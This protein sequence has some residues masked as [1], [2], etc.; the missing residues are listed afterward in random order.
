MEKNNLLHCFLSLML[1]CHKTL[2]GLLLHISLG[3]LRPN[4]EGAD[5]CICS[6]NNGHNIDKIELADSIFWTYNTTRFTRTYQKSKCRDKSQVWEKKCLRKSHHLASTLYLQS[7]QYLPIL[8]IYISQC[9]VEYGGERRIV[10]MLMIKGE[11]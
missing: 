7:Y 1:T 5:C 9:V 11:H 6:E 10:G 2:K 8:N 4:T 3:A